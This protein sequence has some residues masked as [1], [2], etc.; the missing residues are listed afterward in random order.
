MQTTEIYKLP[1]TSPAL[2]AY[3]MDE[4]LLVYSKNTQN[5][6]GFER[7]TAALFLK[8]DEM[9]KTHDLDAIAA[10]FPAVEP[11]ALESMVELAKG[12]ETLDA[13]EY[14][15]DI[16][17]GRYSSGGK[18]RIWYLAD[19]VAFGFHYPD[20]ALKTL[21]HP[22]F[23]HLEVAEEP[24][25]LRNRVAVDFERTDEGWNLFWN[26]KPAGEEIPEPRLA[27]YLQE[28]MMTAVYQS[29]KYLIALHAGSV[30]KDGSAVILPATAESGKT[31]LTATLVARGYTLFSDEVTALDYEGR[32]QPLPF[33][34]NIKD[35]SW[36][37]LKEDFPHL[38]QRAVHKRFDDR[39]IRFLPPQ[40]LH[41]GREKA[42]AVVFPRYEAGAAT[43]LTPISPKEALARI[44]DAS[45]Q[46]QYN[47]DERKFEKIL[48]NL[49][50]L[51]RYELRFS[52]RNEAV[53]VIDELVRAEA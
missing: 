35:G 26:G 3:L 31:T 19:E 45:Y 6:Y 9:V 25:H 23:E 43:A 38:A 39:D 52:D 33:N 53:G 11:E 27:T 16:E 15:A 17:L 34:L 22:V 20:D 36:D 49:I 4:S 8:I 14:E 51:P 5:V 29:H 12:K 1:L 40:N 24:R 32:V 37:I 44:K 50:A 28:R 30:A 10:A 47:M 42:R 48:A 7:E 18:E 2:S 13:V 41:P 46:V 21:L